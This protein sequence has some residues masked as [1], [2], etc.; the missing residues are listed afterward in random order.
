[1]ADM[2][3]SRVGHAT[4]I[5]GQ[6][7]NAFGGKN[8]TVERITIPHNGNPWQMLDISWHDNLKGAF[9][10]TSVKMK[11]GFMIFGGGEH[12]KKPFHF[13]PETQVL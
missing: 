3:K 6:Y 1:M 13:D 5:C 9:G 11:S 8:D 2:N 12:V 10:L 4:I 7:I